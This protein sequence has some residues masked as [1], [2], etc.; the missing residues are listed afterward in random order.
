[1]TADDIDAVVAIAARVHPDFPEGR[2]VLAEKRAL[3]PEGCFVLERAGEALAYMLSHPWRRGD[4]PALDAPLGALP[5][6]ADVWYIHDLAF[7]PDARGTGAA[8]AIVARLAARAQGAGFGAMTL[9]AV[10]GSTG[11]W[12]K[13]GFLIEPGDAALA[14]KLASYGGDARFMV[15]A[16]RQG[17]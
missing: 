15:R 7:L 1:M 3:A 6:D 13:Q 11:F 5:T 14:A 12:E 8:P 9:V 17:L 16:L 2:D 4:P 10:N